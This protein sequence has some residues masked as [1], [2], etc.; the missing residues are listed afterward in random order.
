VN[1][2]LPTAALDAADVLTG[3]LY[4]LET[5]GDADAIEAIHAEAFGPGRFARTAFRLREGVAHDPDLSFVAESGGALI[6]SVRLT[7]IHVG[8]TPGLLLGPLAVRP[9]LKNRGVGKALMR[10]SMEAARVQGH[11]VVLLVGDLPYY[12]PFGF[13]V[14]RPGSIE[15]PGPVDPARLLIAELVPGASDELRGAAKGG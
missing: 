1:L 10:M 9:H 7:P 15:M 14:V 4:R 5:P 12:W 2:S 6:A 13:R 3:V 11:R 8:A